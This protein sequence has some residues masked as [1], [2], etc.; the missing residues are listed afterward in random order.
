MLF[1]AGTRTGNGGATAV[2]ATLSRD[3]KVVA[4]ANRTHLRRAMT[5]PLHARGSSRRRPGH[6]HYRLPLRVYVGR[7]LTRTYAEVLPL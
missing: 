2:S 1:P 4:R 7:H 5:L 6:G 3:G